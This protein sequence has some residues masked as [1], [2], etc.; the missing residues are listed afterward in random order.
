MAIY[1]SLKYSPRIMLH[2]LIS[3]NERCFIC[4]NRANED[5]IWTCVECDNYVLCSKCFGKYRHEHIME[6]LEQWQSKNLDILKL[7]LDVESDQKRPVHAKEHIDEK[8]LSLDQRIQLMAHASYCEADKCQECT[9]IICQKMKK[10]MRHNQ[11]CQEKF[12][13]G[14]T[15]RSSALSDLNA[16]IMMLKSNQA[17]FRP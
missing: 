2:E 16:Q 8:R 1:K 4:G 15:L 13:G 14:S 10:V 12:S 5:S 6:K 17:Q 3:Q 7:L 9:L 11:A